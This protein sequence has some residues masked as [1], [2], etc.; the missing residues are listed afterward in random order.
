M[1]KKYERV[2]PMDYE[3]DVHKIDKGDVASSIALVLFGNRM[4]KGLDQADVANLLGIS[5]GRY[6]EYER[7]ERIPSIV[8]LIAFAN[9]YECTVEDLLCRNLVK[10][11]EKKR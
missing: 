11:K 9:L 3:T 8:T 4:E 5:Q 2:I 7:G 6:G 1:V 10:V